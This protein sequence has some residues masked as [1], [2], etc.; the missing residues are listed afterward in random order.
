MT[1]ISVSH[2]RLTKTGNHCS[3]YYNGVQKFKNL[4]YYIIASDNIFYNYNGV[5]TNVRW[6]LRTLL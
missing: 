1:A 4:I 6:T 5:K 2:E 3:E